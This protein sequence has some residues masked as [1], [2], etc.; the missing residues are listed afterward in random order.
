MWR[1]YSSTAQGI[2]KGNRARTSRQKPGSGNLE[3]G[4]EAESVAE[5]RGL[6]DSL[7]GLLSLLSYVIQGHL[8]RCHTSP[9]GL[10]SFTSIIN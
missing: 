7:Y 2:T 4:T 3:A 6:A 10:G 1:A 5:P 9:D 8:L